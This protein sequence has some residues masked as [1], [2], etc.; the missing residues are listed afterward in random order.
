[1]LVK[2]VSNKDFSGSLNKLGKLLWMFFFFSSV[3]GERNMIGQNQNCVE[4]LL[5]DLKFV[6]CIHVSIIL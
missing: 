6:N 5:G 3:L 4:L 1:M 2:Q